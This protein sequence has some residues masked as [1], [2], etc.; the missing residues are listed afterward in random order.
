MALPNLVKNKSK[1]YL[2]Y[3]SLYYAKTGKNLAEDHF[4]VIAL[5]YKTNSFWKNV[6]AVVNL[7][8]FESNRLEQ[9]QI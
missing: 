3:Y 1:L 5:A 7:N 9:T 4:R 6:A 8:S 2:H